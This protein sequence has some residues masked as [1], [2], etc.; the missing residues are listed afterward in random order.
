MVLFFSPNSSVNRFDTTFLFS[1]KIWRRR[2]QLVELVLAAKPLRAREML[3]LS[4]RKTPG[5]EQEVSLEKKES[6]DQLK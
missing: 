6:L 2:V 4:A 1:A 5:L 3:L